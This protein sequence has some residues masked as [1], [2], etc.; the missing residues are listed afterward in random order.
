M[1]SE[2]L[3]VI[4]PALWAGMLLTVGLMAAPAAF[5]T[6]FPQDAGR[7]VARLLAHEAYVSL[8]LAVLLFGV[9]RSRARTRAAQGQG[10]VL[11]TELLLVL[12]TLFCTVAGH[13][14]IQ[15]MMVAARAG[16]PGPS[17]ATL[18]IASTLLYGLKSILVLAL[19]WRAARGVSPAPSS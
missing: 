19:A 15:P 12:G 7:V 9:E 6:L 16:A 13:F 3:R 1:K 17:F 4:L 11:S 8:A 2:R 14:A 10:S 5:A 18:H